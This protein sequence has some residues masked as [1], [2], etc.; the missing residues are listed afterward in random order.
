MG[1]YET[2]KVIVGINP[3]NVGTSNCG[4]RS[5]TGYRLESYIHAYTEH[6]VAGQDYCKVAPTVSIYSILP[7][8]GYYT[9]L[10]HEK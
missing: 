5:E 9:L 4:Y 8:F 2:T 7:D 3:E 6:M 1:T 10:T